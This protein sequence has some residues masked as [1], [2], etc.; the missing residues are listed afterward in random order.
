MFDAMPA[1][2][3]VRRIAP[4]SRSSSRAS[5]LSVF[6]DISPTTT[7]KSESSTRLRSGALWFSRYFVMSVLPV[8]S[9]LPTRRRIV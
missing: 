6:P 1:A 3:D 7:G 4:A 9:S 5:T 8:S 2:I